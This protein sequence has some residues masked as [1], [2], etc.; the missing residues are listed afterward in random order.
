MLQVPAQGGKGGKRGVACTFN[1]MQGKRLSV[2]ASEGLAVSTPVSLEYNDALF[3]GEVVSCA[4]SDQGWT[5][6]IKVEQILSG[7]QSLMAL[8][9]HL[10]TESVPQP[11]AL[12][13]LNAR[14]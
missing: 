11:L 7:L 5:V 13:P 9:A 2:E 14:N 10:L 12:I 3:L 1:G 8:R 6:E 4:A